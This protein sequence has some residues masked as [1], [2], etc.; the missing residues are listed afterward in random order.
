MVK[1]LSKSF[2]VVLSDPGAQYSAPMFIFLLS[3]TCISTHAISD[4]ISGNRSCI[5]G[6]KCLMP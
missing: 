1:Q 5:D 4:F 3:Y 2:R 6:M